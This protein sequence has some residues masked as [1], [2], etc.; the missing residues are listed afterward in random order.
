FRKWFFLHAAI[1]SPFTFVFD[2]PFGRFAPKGESIFLIDGIKA[3]IVMEIISPI[4]FTCT[5]L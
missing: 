2:A 4:F 5:Y 3:W 1:V